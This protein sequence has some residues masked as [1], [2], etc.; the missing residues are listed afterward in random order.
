MR[1]LTLILLMSLSLSACKPGAV[2]GSTDLLA[3]ITKILKI[4][5]KKSETVAAPQAAE[6]KLDP[7]QLAALKEPPKNDRPDFLFKPATPQTIYFD[8]EGKSLEKP[9]SDGFYRVVKG[10]TDD[11][12][13]VVQD[14]YQQNKRKQ[15]NAFIIKKGGDIKDFDSSMGDS[16]LIW[17]T[18]DGAVEMQGHYQNGKWQGLGAFYDQGKLAAYIDDFSDDRIRLLYLYPQEGLKAV[19]DFNQQNE[20]ITYTYYY[21]SGSGMF[22]FVSYANENEKNSI[23]AW[24]Q[25]GEEV[26]PRTMVEQVTPLFE[27]SDA[28]VKRFLNQMSDSNSDSNSSQ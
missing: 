17:Y 14:F 19:I 24:N 23:I 3:G 18:P 12:R 21:L 28:L 6:W 11:G 5:G 10:Q 22:K 4:F 8:K 9:V 16:H 25:D 20:S 15:T 26:D 2:E 27:E 7:Q 13:A 1:K